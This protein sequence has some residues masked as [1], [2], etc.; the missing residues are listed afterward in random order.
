MR[1]SH[2]D[3]INIGYKNERQYKDEVGLCSIYGAGAC[4]YLYRQKAREVSV[5]KQLVR[6]VIE[7]ECQTC[8]V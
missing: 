8:Y 7:A 1:L 5:A 2:T 4:L 3:T 6:F